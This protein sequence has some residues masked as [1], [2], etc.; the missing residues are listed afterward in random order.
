[1]LLKNRFI[2]HWLPAIAWCVVIFIQSAF[3][4]PNIE[5]PWP[6]FDKTAHVGIYALL[7][8]LCCRALSTLAGWRDRAFRLLAAATVLTALYGLSDEW[9]QSFVA[10]RTAEGADLLA[11][12][13]GGLIGSGLYLLV[14]KMIARLPGRKSFGEG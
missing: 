6:F 5:P 12:L 4:T 9:H 11:D 2:T 8:L 14:R 10:A 3:A 1:M 13:L 7:G